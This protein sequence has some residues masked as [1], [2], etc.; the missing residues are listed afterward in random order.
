M[1]KRSRLFRRLAAG[2]EYVGSR[3]GRD[4]APQWDVSNEPDRDINAQASVAGNA[5][6]RPVLYNAPKNGGQFTKEV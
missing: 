2:T 5:F 1:K 6:S 4:N 3:S